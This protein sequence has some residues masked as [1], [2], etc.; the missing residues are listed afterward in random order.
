MCF[1]SGKKEAQQLANSQAQANALAQQQQQQAAAREE[2]IRRGQDTID[3]G[4]SG[5]N[6]G[7]YNLFKQKFVDAQNPQIDYQRGSA[8]DKLSAALTNRGVERSS[9]AGNAYGDIEAA[10][11]GARG[12]AANDA[13][14]AANA[15]RGRVESAKTNLYSINSQSADPSR[16]ANQ[17]Q[18][19]LTALTPLPATNAVGDIFG[20][21]LNPFVNY[22]SANSYRPYQ[23][24]FTQPGGSS[25]SK[26]WSLVG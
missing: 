26:S 22:M 3:Q 11:A 23:G 1:G 2:R 4:F 25:N 8:I 16:V 5:F 20:A 13:S 21:A 7:Y 19:Q 17:V 6:D 15:L 10:W 9:I 12:K 24:G 14:E 18:G